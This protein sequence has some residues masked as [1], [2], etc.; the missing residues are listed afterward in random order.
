MQASTEFTW[1]WWT[2]K[3]WKCKNRKS[4][5][6]CKKLKH[7]LAAGKMVCHSSRIIGLFLRRSKF[8]SHYDLT[9]AANSFE[10]FDIF[11]LSFLFFHFNR[12]IDRN[13]GKW[14]ILS[15]RSNF[16]WLKDKFFSSIIVTRRFADA[17]KIDWKTFE[18]AK[19]P[20][21]PGKIVNALDVLS[22]K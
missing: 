6:L 18:S 10:P 5:G 22:K 8:C 12:S 15:H 7:I 13:L 9:N 20:Q 3:Y 19:I 2:L 14:P 11:P 16:Q 17:T 21:L 4:S 1:M